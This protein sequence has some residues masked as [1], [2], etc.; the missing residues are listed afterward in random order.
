MTR[1]EAITLDWACEDAIDAL[2]EHSKHGD[3]IGRY[4]PVHEAAVLQ[5]CIDSY[6][7]NMNKFGAAVMPAVVF[8]ELVTNPRW[9]ITVIPIRRD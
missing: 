7:Y 8:S 5:A 4:L 9:Q 3:V 1:G 6:H 2:F